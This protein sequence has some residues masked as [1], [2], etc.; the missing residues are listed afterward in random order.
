MEPRRGGWSSE[1]DGVVEVV[2]GLAQEVV[3]RTQPGDQSR[4]LGDRSSSGQHTDRDGDLVTI[5]REAWIVAQASS[6]L[7]GPEL[8]GA[9]PGLKVPS[10]RLVQ[11][12]GMA[13]TH[14]DGHVRAVA[15]DLADDVDAGLAVELADP[16]G[17]RFAGGS[18]GPILQRRI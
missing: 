2:V 5:V 17:V 1:R 6:V 3:A 12:V 14:V 15:L 18:D 8:L 11:A 10:Q 7:A 4:L 16:I 9:A 13:L